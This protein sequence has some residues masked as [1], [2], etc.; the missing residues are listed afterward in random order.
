VTERLPVVPD[1]VK[2][3][4][5]RVSNQKLILL[6]ALTLIHQAR[7]RLPPEVVPGLLDDTRD[8]VV[9][10]TRSVSGQIGQLLM[11][12][13]PRWTAPAAPNPSDRTVWDEGTSAERLEWLRVLR[14]ADPAGARNLL[15]DNWS[16]ES[17]NNRAEFLAVLADGLSIADQDFLLAAVGDRSRVVSAAA[18]TLLTHLPD[19]T[20]RR[21]M[22]KLAARHLTIGR[23]LLRTTVKV[24]RPNPHEFAPWPDPDADPWTVLMSRIDPAEW[25]RTFNG[26]L[27][28]LIAG[29]ETELDPLQSGFRLAAIAFRDAD[30][31]RVLI[32]QMFDRIGPKAP[33]VVDGALWAMLSPSDSTAQLDRLLTHPMARPDLIASAATVFSRP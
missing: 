4:L 24:T 17:A 33:P 23:R 16:R 6:E 32:T 15:A 21:D 11:T 5:S 22:R 25:R 27:L 30:L 14:R 2:Q 19:S 18:T 28:K 7:L 29:G 20:L 8:E 3:V 12:K 1:V 26:D 10:A 9:A 13:N 31:A